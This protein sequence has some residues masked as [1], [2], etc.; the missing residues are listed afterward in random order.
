MKEIMHLLVSSHCCVLG[1]SYVNN[2]VEFIMDILFIVKEE[3]GVQ[4]V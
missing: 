2:Q 1:L 4:R 3:A